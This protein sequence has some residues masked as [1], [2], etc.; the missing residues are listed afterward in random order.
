MKNDLIDIS[1][2]DKKLTEYLTNFTN[3]LDE[4][5]NNIKSNSDNNID[6]IKTQLI[7]KTKDIINNLL[8]RINS[9]EKE[10][11]QIQ[12]KF[13]KY[14]ANGELKKHFLENQI[15]NVYKKDNEKTK[16]IKNK[17]KE[18]SELK[19]DLLNLKTEYLQI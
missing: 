17:T 5:I 12:K 11:S 7:D 2:T 18:I 10:N 16:Q 19:A 1:L 14:K 9:L 13:E 6:N 3:D 8:T 4:I 15:K